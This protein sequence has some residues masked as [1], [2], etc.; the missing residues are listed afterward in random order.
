MLPQPFPFSPSFLVH[1]DTNISHSTLALACTQQQSHMLSHP[2]KKSL[3]CS[4]PTQAQ[5]LCSS[6]VTQSTLQHHTRGRGIA[7]LTLTQRRKPA[8]QI[9]TNS[10]FFAF[11]A[12][13]CTGPSLPN[14]LRRESISRK[15]TRIK[16]TLFPASCQLALWHSCAS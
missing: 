4:E 12:S 9:W 2:W 3:F 13:T 10:D 8:E 1:Q 6:T 16:M 15:T 5:L 11:A 7:R 14:T